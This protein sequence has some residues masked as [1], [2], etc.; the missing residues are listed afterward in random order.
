M[1]D[2]DWV[3]L[4]VERLDRGDIVHESSMTRG[5]A[6]DGARDYQQTKAPLDWVD[7]GDDMTSALSGA[8]RITIAGGI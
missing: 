4:R 6:F 8:Y 3:T 5:A 7:L 1:T 2:H